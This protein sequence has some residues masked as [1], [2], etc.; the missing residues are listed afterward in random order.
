MKKV[1]EDGKL[2]IYLHTEKEL[3]AYMHPLRQKILRELEICP[4]GLTAKQLADRLHISPSSAGHHLSALE[5]IGVAAFSHTQKI[6]GFTAKFYKRVPA[7]VCMGETEP[8]AREIQEVLVKNHVEQ[9]TERFFS[10]LK[11]LEAQGV[12]HLP[13]HGDALTGVI[14]LTPQEA[15]QLMTQILDFLDAR[16]TPTPGACPYEYA[17]V[18]YNAKWEAEN[19]EETGS[20]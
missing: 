17:A 14:Y 20:L 12:T 4:Q 18:A 15:G 8:A 2:R 7:S 19:H 5:A 13:Q 10:A 11:D 16:S 6:H 9:I 1:V 3:R